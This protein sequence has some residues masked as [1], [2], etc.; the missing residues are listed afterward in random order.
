M[1]PAEQT[2]ETTTQPERQNFDA[3]ITMLKTKF[4]PAQL[5]DL[6]S[7]ELHSRFRG[8]KEAVAEFAQ[9]VQI[10]TKQAYP[11][12]GEVACQQFISRWALQNKL[13]KQLLNQK[14][15]ILMP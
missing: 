3:L 5:S 9:A 14:G 4:K 15:K 13:M 10:L 12:V 7:V 1:G 11:E 8:P 2:Y 6:R